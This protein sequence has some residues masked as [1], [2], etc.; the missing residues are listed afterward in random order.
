PNLDQLR[1]E[2]MSLTHMFTPATTCSPSRHALYTGLY[3]VRSG[4]YPNHTQVFEGTQSFFRYLK[5]AGYRVGLQGKTHV[6]P[7]KSFPYEHVAGKNPDDFPA[8]RE[9]LSRDKE[10]PWLLV[11][12]SNDPHSPWNRGPKELHDP[13]QITVPPYLYDNPTTRTLLCDYYREIHKLDA[14]VG[15][16]MKMLDQTKQ[17]ENTLVLFVSEQ[18]SSFPYGGKWSLYDNGIRI[19]TLARWPGKIA[20]GSTSEAMVQYVDVVPT[21]LEAA[22]IDPKTIDT[23]CPDADGNTGFDGRSFLSVLLG[24]SREHREVIFSQ[25]TTVGINGYKAPYPMRAARDR[26]FKYIRNLAPENEYW[27]NGIHGAEPFPSW[28]RD[29]KSDPSLAARVRFLSHR[30]AEELYDLEIDPLETQNLS[31]DPD[32]AEVQRKLSQS[33][34]EWMRQQGD[35]GMETELAAHDRQPG[36]RRRSAEENRD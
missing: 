31:D 34:D 4:A 33:L 6:G 32:Y 29:S 17:R 25:H 14:Q 36:R 15:R 27:I 8:T 24:Q 26:R 10:Q 11:F 23:G 19:A 1:Q 16:L 3:C 13:E 30:P 7:P 35:Q 5:D 9:F 22:G 12:A 28:V 18:G 20:P 21:F 2:G